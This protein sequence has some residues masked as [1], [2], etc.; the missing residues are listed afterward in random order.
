MVHVA[1]LTLVVLRHVEDGQ[2]G[3]DSPEAGREGGAA[4]AVPHARV[5]DRVHMAHVPP[6]VDER[7]LALRAERPRQQDHQIP[8]GQQLKGRCTVRSTKH[9][10]L[11]VH[12]TG[13]VWL[14]T[15]GGCLQEVGC[16]AAPHA[17]LR[18]MSYAA[19]SSDGTT[20]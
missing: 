20:R 18:D 19:G 17:A 6:L 15:P 8:V 11:L 13:P 14:A 16:P 7:V 5:P 1:A 4:A 12:I 3:V 2:L 9:G 10:M